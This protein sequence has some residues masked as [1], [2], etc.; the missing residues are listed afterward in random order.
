[1]VT[2]DHGQP[3]QVQGYPVPEPLTNETLRGIA[4]GEFPRVGEAAR[5]AGE[6]LDLRARV[7][8]LEALLS[9]ARLATLRAAEA[10][11]EDYWD[12]GTLST[13]KYRAAAE[14]ERGANP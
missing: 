10:T 14:A 6:L 7:E 8:E 11:I 2:H 1:M 5:L 9:P 12:T 3:V 13:A 4:R